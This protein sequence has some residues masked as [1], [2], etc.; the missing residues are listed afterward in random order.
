[1]NTLAILGGS[2]D[3]VHNAHIQM[4]IRAEQEFGLD[5]IIF[6]PAYKPPH[7]DKLSAS[8]EDRY[9]MLG[10]ALEKYPKFDID[11]YELN[12]KREV[13]SYQML[14][15]FRIKYNNYDIKMIIGADSFN[16]LGA[17]RQA[18]YICKNY[19]FYVLQRPNIKINKTSPYYKY[20]KFSKSVMYDISSTEIRDMVKKGQDITDFVP[21]EIVDYIRKNKLYL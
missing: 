17:W 19:G 3:P 4:A 11:M 1:M 8:A 12:L 20:C 18:E 21:E 6:V 14:D 5:K 2:F 16:Q 10:F 13:F 15:Y 7:K 9:N